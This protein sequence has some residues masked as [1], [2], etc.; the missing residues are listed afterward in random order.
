MRLIYYVNMNMLV[1]VVVSA[2]H[3]QRRAICTQHYHGNKYEE[4]HDNSK[5]YTLR[6]P[7]FLLTRLLGNCWV[8]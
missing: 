2:N 3:T 6:L 4:D 5:H 7:N 1:N 8:S